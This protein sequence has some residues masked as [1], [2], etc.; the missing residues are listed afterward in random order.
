MAPNGNRIRVFDTGS[1]SFIMFE[2]GH[3]KWWKYN[4]ITQ[5]LRYTR[6]TEQGTTYYSFRD[7]PFSILTSLMEISNDELH[8]FMMVKVKGVYEQL[9][10]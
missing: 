7:V 1:F 8:T 9:I 3:M 10:D 2:D 6:E 5:S 4:T